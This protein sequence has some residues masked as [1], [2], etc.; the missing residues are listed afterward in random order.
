MDTL[1][2]FGKLLRYHRKQTRDPLTENPLSQ[3]R[4]GELVHQS[5]A[6]I[7]YWENDQRWIDVKDR[8]LLLL[9]LKV[10]S[11]HGGIANLGAANALL[12]AG[13]YRSLDEEE[14]R[15]L[16][17]FYLPQAD[18]PLLSEVLAEPLPEEEPS[19]KLISISVLGMLFHTDI[20]PDESRLAALVIKWLGYPEELITPE[21]W[22][23][24]LVL[25]GLWAAASWSWLRL[26]RWPYANPID[27]QWTLLSWV[28]ACIVIPIV[29]G[30]VMRADRQAFLEQKTSKR[31]DILFHRTLGAGMGYIVGISLFFVLGLFL[32]YA[33]LWPLPR[34]VVMVLALLPLLLAYAAGRRMPWN[35]FKAYHVKRGDE[36]ALT[37]DEGDKIIVLTWMLI[38][39]ILASAIYFAPDITLNPLKGI[40]SIIGCMVIILV[41]KVRHKDQDLTDFSDQFRHLVEKVAVLGLVALGFVAII[42]SPASFAI[43]I[44]SIALA[45]V[46]YPLLVALNLDNVDAF[47]F[48]V[49]AVAAIA[50]LLLVYNHLY[51]M[52]LALF[53]VTFFF[54]VVL[55]RR[56]FRAWLPLTLAITLFTASFVLH[57]FDKSALPSVRLGYTVAAGLLIF[58][59]IWRNRQARRAAR[60]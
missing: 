54:W 41:W 53:V 5:T 34:G 37:P 48:F 33:T 32:Y 8:A 52:V 55:Y 17:R 44:S 39:L 59:Q 38:P 25:V 46:V 49:L 20:E 9:V 3:S 60:E 30:L 45:I 24:L 43:G 1:F 36:Q 18:D 6:T 12:H 57:R 27:A 29:L 31:S 40:L 21:G 47:P 26:F 15:R 35:S 42:V 22:L 2:T 11:E 14:S 51:D 23:R 16:Q 4:L 56:H 10:L 7:S 28:G 19:P 50:G 58:W 13:D